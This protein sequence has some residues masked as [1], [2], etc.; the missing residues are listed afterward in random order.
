MGQVRSA[1]AATAC[2]ER[3]GGVAAV[4][5]AAAPS[6][7]AA[8][9]AAAAV[10]QHPAHTD[11]HTARRG[12]LLPGRRAGPRHTH[13]HARKQPQPRISTAI[14]TQTLHMRAHRQT[15]GGATYSLRCPRRRVEA[16]THPR[17]HTA[18][19]THQHHPSGS[20]GGTSGAAVGRP[21]GAQ[22]SRHSYSVAADSSQQ[23][24]ATTSKA[25]AAGGGAADVPRATAVRCGGTFR[26]IHRDLLPYPYDCVRPYSY[27][28]AQYSCTRVVATGMQQDTCH[29]TCTGPLTG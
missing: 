9:P 7:A 20:S 2:V 1:A 13:T 6:A 22:H 8:P 11:S 25:A 19:P 29:V 16:Y 17:T 10:S 5:T 23:G 28:T 15:H 21:T 18:A 4:V 26:R 24:P 27:C 14:R 3:S 12:D